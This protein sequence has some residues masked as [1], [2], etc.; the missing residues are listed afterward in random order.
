M[1]LCACLLIAVASLAGGWIP[2]LARPTHRRMQLVVSFVAGAMAG[3][4]VLDLLPD[5]LHL[6]TIDAALGWMIAGFLGLFLLERFLPSHCHDVGGDDAGGCG[7]DH[8]ITWLG[9]L[10]GL[11]IHG[12]LAGAA[13]GAAWQDGVALGLLLAIALHKPLDGFT[14]GAMLAVA[15][16]PRGRRHLLNVLL[17]LAVPLGVGLFLLAGRGASDAAI[18]AALAFAAGMFL[19]IALGDLLPELHFHGHDRLALSVALLLGLALAWGMTRVEG[20]HAEAG[21]HPSSILPGDEA[22]AHE[23][24]HRHYSAPRGGAD[25]GAC[26]VNDV[27]AMC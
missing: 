10:I 9:A 13:L 20:A 18:A 21:D 26:R 25:R 3:I 24:R 12:V 23:S 15:G 27:L 7:H 19:C 16:A 5:A 4:A 14:L 6:G 22:P 11:S 8:R 17:A 2:L 1:L